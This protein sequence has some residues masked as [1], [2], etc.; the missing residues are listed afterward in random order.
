ML[1]LYRE[2]NFILLN[3]AITNIP[4][5]IA[6]IHSVELIIVLLWTSSRPAHVMILVGTLNQFMI[7]ALRSSGMTW[8]RRYPMAGK[9]MPTPTSR[10]RKARKERYKWLPL[11]E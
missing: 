9:Y 3:N 4:V 5:Q 8:D 11:V 1:L 10:M 6:N 7:P 2:I